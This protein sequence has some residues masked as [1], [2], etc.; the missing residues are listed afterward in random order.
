MLDLDYL[1]YLSASRLHVLLVGRGLTANSYFF[2]PLHHLLTLQFCLLHTARFHYGL[3]WAWWYLSSP[4]QHGK[5]RGCLQSPTGRTCQKCLAWVCKSVSTVK[6]GHTWTFTTADQ[7]QMSKAH[8]EGAEFDTGCKVMHT[9]TLINRKRLNHSG[10]G[11][12][13]ATIFL[14]SY[15]LSQHVVQLWPLVVT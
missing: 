8:V 6:W 13:L 4:A 7:K 1:H 9:I 10:Y 5:R 3:Y 2:P 12:C 14:Y 15:G 11:C